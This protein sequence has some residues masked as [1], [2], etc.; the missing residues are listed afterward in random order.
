MLSVHRTVG[1]LHRTNRNLEN[2]VRRMDYS[3]P[4][5]GLG[6]HELS[7]IK[8]NSAEK[9]TCQ[10]EKEPGSSEM[11]G[12]PAIGMKFTAYG[13]PFHICER[14]HEEIGGHLYRY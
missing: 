13:T 8:Q 9:F 12:G 10:L 5:E 1:F 3:R 7:P 14:H 11:C 6:V 4:R 2:N